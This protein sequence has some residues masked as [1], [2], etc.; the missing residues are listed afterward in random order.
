MT[1]AADPLPFSAVVAELRAAGCV[2]AEDE[3]RLLIAAGA[4][5]IILAVARMTPGL[6]GAI[7][8]IGR[9][10][11]SVDA[12]RTAVEAVEQLHPLARV[13]VVADG[14][15]T[16]GDTVALLAAAWTS[17]ISPQM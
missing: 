2:F 12:V 15:V 17:T 11:V 4:T 14:L 1:S 5:Q 8:R 10:G 6:L 9:R 13:L 16:T 7:S 3:A